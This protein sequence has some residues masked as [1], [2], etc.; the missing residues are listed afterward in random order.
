[1]MMV[2]ATSCKEESPDDNNYVY[3]MT[4]QSQVSLNLKDTDESQGSMADPSVDL[5]SKTVARCVTMN[6]TRVMPSQ[7]RPIC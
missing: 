1:M 2:V 5:L 4:I 3:Y 6:P 7:S